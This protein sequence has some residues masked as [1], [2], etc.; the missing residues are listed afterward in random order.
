[1]KISRTCLSTSLDSTFSNLTNN[2]KN[3]KEKHRIE[4]IIIKALFLRKY[5]SF[6]QSYKLFFDFLAI[7]FSKKMV[8]AV[9]ASILYTSLVQADQKL[10]L[11]KNPQLFC[12]YY[13]L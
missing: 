4:R 7:F 1:V 6:Y 9:F 12:F 5:F 13:T 8:V 11:L 10:K 2:N 3:I